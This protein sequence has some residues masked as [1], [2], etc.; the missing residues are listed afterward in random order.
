MAR[1]YSS[2]AAALG[3]EAPSQHRA[4]AG[5]GTALRRELRIPAAGAEE[6]ALQFAPLTANAGR[7]EA[8][9]KDLTLRCIYSQMVP[10]TR[11]AEQQT[12][13]VKRHF[14]KHTGKINI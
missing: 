9:G 11:Q 10:N 5:G 14:I 7:A 6:A 12:G 8:T 1:S 13:T 4:A 2:T 3:G